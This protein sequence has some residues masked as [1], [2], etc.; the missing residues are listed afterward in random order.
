[1]ISGYFVPTLLLTWQ[2]TLQGHRSYLCRS[3]CKRISLSVRSV[4]QAD[5]TGQTSLWLAGVS[6]IE[7]STCN[8]TIQTVCV[9]IVYIWKIINGNWHVEMGG[10][11]T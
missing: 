6:C 11:G 1:M 7:D 10:G 3:G 2:G 8:H 5:S 4:R 9:S